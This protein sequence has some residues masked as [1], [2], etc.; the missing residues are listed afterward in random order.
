MIATNIDEVIVYLDQIIER[1]KSEQS[2]LGYFAALYN[3][4]TKEVKSKL[5]QN[6]FDND[7]RMEL[8]DVRFANRY[9]AAYTQYRN[10]ERTTKSWELAFNSS[11]VYKLIVLQHLLLGMNAHINLDLGIA[12][13][14]ISDATTIGSLKSDFN[15]INAILAE[16]AEEVEKDL[17]EIWPTLL[18]ILK[19]FKDVDNFLIDFSMTLARDGAWK[20]ANELIFRDEGTSLEELIAKRDIEI[21]EFGR[22]ITKKGFVDGLIFWIIRLGERGTATEKI[23]ILES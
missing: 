22:S 2:T 17:S 19:I 11:K 12:A 1:A 20:F 14:E 10:G 23:A 15:K 8:L 21:A 4:V 13:A 6:Y 9:L 18:K 16:L 7:E 5:G 3:K